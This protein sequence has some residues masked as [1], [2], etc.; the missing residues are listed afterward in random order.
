MG[1]TEVMKDSGGVV[2]AGS[3]VGDGPGLVGGLGPDHPDA[4]VAGVVGDRTEREHVPA[5]HQVGPLGDVGVD[6]LEL[7]RQRHG[8][9]RHDPDEVR[10]HGDLPATSRWRRPEL[11]QDVPR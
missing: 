4:V 1:V 6:D 10:V 2:T 8:A 3:P 7:V 9:R 11:R 5:L